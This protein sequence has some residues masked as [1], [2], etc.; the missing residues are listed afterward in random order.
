MLLTKSLKFYALTVVQI[1]NFRYDAS[2]SVTSISK[3]KFELAVIAE[4]QFL[5][6]HSSNQAELDTLKLAEF[7]TQ[8]EVFLLSLCFIKERD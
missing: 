2:S 4:R 1:I 6:L 3:L 8:L 7:L 5:P